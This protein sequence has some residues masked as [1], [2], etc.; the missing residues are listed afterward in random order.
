VTRFLNQVDSRKEPQVK[1]LVARRTPR[2][3]PIFLA[4]RLGEL[5]GAY[6]VTNIAVATMP[7]DSSPLV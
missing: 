4:L 7:V 6:V 1:T 3:E 5:I 2:E